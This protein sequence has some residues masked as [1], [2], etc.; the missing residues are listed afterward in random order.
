MMQRY[1]DLLL[2]K[3][4]LLYTLLQQPLL[5]PACEQLCSQLNKQL[6]LK[7]VCLLSRLLKFQLSAYLHN[8]Y[9]LPTLVNSLL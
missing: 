5:T 9:Y 4:V 7:L 6:E 2:V 8:C 1:S 3:I